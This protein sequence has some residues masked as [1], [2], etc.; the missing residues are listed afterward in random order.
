[1]LHGSVIDADERGDE[2]GRI[3]APASLLVLAGFEAGTAGR[4]VYL[5]VSAWSLG[6]P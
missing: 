1:M 2:D 5:P 4:S 3:D 6:L